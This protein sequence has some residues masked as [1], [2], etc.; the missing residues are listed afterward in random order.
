M[1]ILGPDGKP[2]STAPPVSDEVVQFVE[3]AREIAAQGDP[4][5]ALQ[6]IVFAFQ[7]DVESDLVI[8][9]HQF[10]LA[11]TDG[12]NERIRAECRTRP[13]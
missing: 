10:E 6:Q 11:F 1:R 5:S 7:Q 3:R 8:D 12:R 4:A 13:V 2:I 9:A